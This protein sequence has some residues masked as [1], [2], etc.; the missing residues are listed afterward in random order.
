MVWEVWICGFAELQETALS[1][2][3]STELFGKRIAQTNPNQKTYHV[4][5]IPK[6]IFFFYAQIRMRD[7]N[8]VMSFYM[9]GIYFGKINKQ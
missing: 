2:I 8:L 4:N 7:V 9:P 3:T 1:A 5:Y 6:H